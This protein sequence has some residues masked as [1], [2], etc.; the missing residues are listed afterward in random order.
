MSSVSPADCRLHDSALTEAL[1]SSTQTVQRTSLPRVEGFS[2]LYGSGCARGIAYRRSVWCAP[3]SLLFAKGFDHARFRTFTTARPSFE[4]E[5][6]CSFLLQRLLLFDKVQH[7]LFFFLQLNPHVQYGAC[8]PRCRRW[9][10]RFSL[11]P[12]DSQRDFFFPSHG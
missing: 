12:R 1:F 9:K 2:L 5:P 6:R 4:K 3:S 8:F 10:R 11:F 7:H